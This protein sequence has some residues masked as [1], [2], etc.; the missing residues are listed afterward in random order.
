MFKQPGVKFEI[1]SITYT[2]NP[3]WFNI[4]NRRTVRPQM[5]GVPYPAGG[6]KVFFVNTI[7][8]ASGYN[9]DFFTVISKQATPTTLSHELG[10]ACG[11][12]DIYVTEGG[13]S[14]SNVGAVNSNHMVATDWGTGYYDRKLELHNLLPRLLMYGVSNP[15]KG[16]IPHGD[17]YGVYEAQWDPVAG[18]WIT[19]VGMVKVGL[20]S[21]G[22]TRQP[23]HNP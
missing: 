13:N 4:T 3:V 17:I 5:R 23:K 14:I 22:F 6:L 15:Q 18:Q 12:T 8:G 9:N 2:N 1:A 21:T 16:Y 19:A 10:H 20:D 7:T 11:W